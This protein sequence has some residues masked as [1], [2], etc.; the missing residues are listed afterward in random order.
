[1][2]YFCV[3]INYS[4]WRS[5]AIVILSV[6]LSVTFVILWLN[7]L[8]TPKITWRLIIAGIWLTALQC[9]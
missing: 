7:K 6:G 8:Y 3:A 5:I 2:Y 4:V 1:M 9:S